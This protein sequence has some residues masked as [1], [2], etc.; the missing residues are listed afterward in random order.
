MTWIVLILGTAFFQAVKDVFLKRALAKTK[1]LV[2]VWGYCLVAAAC[3]C[4]AL[5]A[6][7]IPETGPAFWAALWPGVALGALTLVLYVTALGASDLSLTLPMLT[8]TPMFMMV[9]SP[10]M[11]GEF[12]GALGWLGIAAIVAGSYL[13]NIATAR[14]GIFAPFRALF[15]ERGPRLMLL[16]A[17]LW[18]I[19]GNLDKIGL[20]GSSPLYWITALY[21]LIA[22]A[23][24]PFALLSLKRGGWPAPRDRFDLA[25]AGFFEALSI[26]LQ[27]F[28]LTMAIVP[29]VIA[30]KRLSVIV[31]VVLGAVV[32]KERGLPG[33]LS[34]A[35]LM[36][37]GV[38][39]IAFFG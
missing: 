1:P 19:S 16:V 37:L 17:F 6:A 24:T 25:R 4:P 27:M 13:L 35:I 32:F 15:K 29:Y 31:G 12:P 2:V 26:G 18:S 10:L 39:F 7:G 22:L 5:W 3:F 36:V 9:T 21:V 30:V 20:L 34:G 8:F 38:F 14:R 28:A 23:L 11:T 33:R